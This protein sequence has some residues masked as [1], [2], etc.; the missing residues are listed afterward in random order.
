MVFIVILG[1]VYRVFL[2][3]RGTLFGLFFDVL[4]CVLG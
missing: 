4:I 1:D 3:S 2:C